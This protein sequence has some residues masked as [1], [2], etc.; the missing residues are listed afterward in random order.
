M[1]R[2]TV[3]PEVEQ[4]DRTTSEMRGLF[5]KIILGDSR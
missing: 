1:T 3:Y 4:C 2:N 5:P